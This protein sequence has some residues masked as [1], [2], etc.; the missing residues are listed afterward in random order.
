MSRFRNTVAVA[1]LL[2]PANSLGAFS[3]VVGPPR[4]ELH[5]SPGSV[6]RESLDISSDA[7]DFADFVVRTA[8]WELSPDGNVVFSEADLAVGSCRPWV[9]LERRDLRLAPRGRRK[10]RFEVHVPAEA[11]AGEC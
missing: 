3:A 7:L 1:A 5:A 10:F 6:A 9:R 2:V 8:D 11:N 4:F